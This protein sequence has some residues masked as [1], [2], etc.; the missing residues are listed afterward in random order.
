MNTLTGFIGTTD[1][2]TADSIFIWKS[3]STPAASGYKTY[4]LLNGAPSLPALLRWVVVGDSSLMARD[5]EPILPGNRSAFVRTRDGV[6][7]YTTPAPWA[8]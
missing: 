2:K 8:P 1:F 7:Q 6:P 5:A 4:Y 3:D